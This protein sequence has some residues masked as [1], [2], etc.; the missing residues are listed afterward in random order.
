[1]S[2]KIFVIAAISALVLAGCSA[3][4]DGGDKGGDNVVK[5]GVIAPLSGPA[6]TYGEDASNVY[7]M[8]YQDAIA[9]NVI[10]E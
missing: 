10:G 7:Q 5:I 6:A 1:M 3:P 2:K 9:A 4:S 8:A